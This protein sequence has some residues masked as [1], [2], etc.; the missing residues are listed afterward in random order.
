MTQLPIEMIRSSET[1]QVSDLIPYRG[2]KCMRNVWE[3]RK[4]FS[5]WCYLGNQIYEVGG[6]YHAHHDSEDSEYVPCCH[7]VQRTGELCRPCR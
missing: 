1:L 2:E 6:H 3:V 4:V 5:P 7:L